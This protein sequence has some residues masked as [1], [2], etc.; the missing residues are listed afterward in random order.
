[1][2]YT[3]YLQVDP[4]FYEIIEALA[5]NKKEL[6]VFFFL[7]ENT[8]GQAKGK[9]SET[10]KLEDGEFLKLENGKRVILDRIITIN[11]KPGPAFDE[12]DSYANA[13]LSCQGGYED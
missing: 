4:D 3:K 13:S 1:M 11:G 10:E 12:Y 6:N 2:E 5:E 8:I 9:F 7:P